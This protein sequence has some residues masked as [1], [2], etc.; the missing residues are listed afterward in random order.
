MVKYFYKNNK[1]IVEDYQ[2]AKH[3]ASFLPAIAGKNGKP[4]WAFFASVGQCMGGFGIDDRNTPYTPFDSATLAYQNIPIKGFRTF[5]K[6][7]GRVYTPFFY[8]KGVQ[9]LEIDKT[10]FSISE[11]TSKYFIRITYSTVSNRDYPG[12]IRHVE[13]KSK[14]DGEVEIVDGLPILF[15]KGLTNG[16]YKELVFLMSAYCQIDMGNKRPFV[17]FKT[18]TKDASEVE[19]AKE[20]NG[21]FSIDMN[22]ERLDNIVELGVLFGNDTTLISAPNFIDGSY[23]DRVKTQQ[24]ENQLP[25][26]FSFKKKHFN[27]SETYSFMTLFSSADTVEEF[28]GNINPLTYNKLIEMMKETDDLVKSMLPKHIHTSNPI[29][30]DY[31]IE[32]VLDN[33][34]RGG[35]PTKI[36]NQIYYLYSR[37]HGDMERDYNFFSIP[38]TYYSS[39]P[40][41][42]RDVNQNRRNDLY[43]VNEI[44]DYNIYL[45]F[46]LIQADGQNPLSVKP[47]KFNYVGSKSLFNDFDENI[48]ENAYKLA[49]SYYPSEMYTFIKRNEKHINRP[50]EEMFNKIINNSK[51]SVEACFGEGYWIDHWTYNVDL[52]EN[53]ASIYPDKLEEL[54]FRDD[55]KYFYS[56]VYVEPRDE[57]YCLRKDGTIRQYGAL[58]L[59]NFKEENEKLGLTGQETLWLKDNDG[60]EVTT[61]L[62]SKIFNLILI[63]FSTLDANQMGIEME[64]EKPGWND[65]MNGLPGLFASA[66]SE[67]IELLRLMKCYREIAINFLDKSFDVLIEQREFF[68]EIKE[69]FTDL[70]CSMHDGIIDKQNRFDY[71]NKATLARER[72]RKRLRYNASGKVK[73]VFVR[74]SIIYFD[75]MMRTLSDGIKRAKELGNGIIPSYIINEVVRYEKLYKTNHLGYE[76]VKPLEFKTVLIPDFLEASA[77]MAKLGQEF[78]DKETYQKIYDSDLRDQE[79]GLYKT[80]ADI[81]DA[82]FEIGRVHAFTKG[83]LERECDFLHMGY[84]YLLGLLK[85]G[86]YEEFFKECKINLVC[87]MDVNVYGRSPIE[88]SSFIVPTCNPNK[89]LHGQGFLA[90][91]TGANA[92]VIDMYFNLFVGKE[93]FKMEDNELT[94]NLDPKLPAEYFDKNNKVTFELFNKVLVIYHNPNRLDC[95][96]GVHLKY[97]VN[98]QEMDVIKGDLAK[99]IRDKKIKKVEVLIY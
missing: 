10:Y 15:P 17:K 43:F 97:K 64:C 2:N 31:I 38:S 83:W 78:F 41:N 44:K 7:D 72:L 30:D 81:E 8:S 85:A 54:L 27:K 55:Y 42:F 45:F 11:N 56:H 68:D 16:V 61:T 79:L 84:K 62:I 66:M 26:A 67:T 92:E 29:F 53:Y 47:L 90:R 33:N 6:I 14:V 20:G 71:W 76:V 35:F 82:P 51:Q 59:K 95:Y 69:A 39:G 99:K 1:F 37:K 60:N 18:S 70:N 4:L 52:L 63:K 24:T 87:N 73:P 23:L 49:K 91:L 13:F 21:Y 5:I 65:A 46:S 80:C 96:K 57:K 98:G 19:L 77:R 32:S 58:N 94:F 22:N 3:F 86:L 74:E 88:S 9:K 28:E 93:L 48:R 12:L 89:A 34:L 75:D 50:Y 40:G 25:C 36:G